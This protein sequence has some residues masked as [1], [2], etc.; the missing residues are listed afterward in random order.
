VRDAVM[1]ERMP[2][3]SQRKVHQADGP[4]AREAAQHGVWA[5]PQLHSCC[6]VCGHII[7]VS[8]SFCSS[9]LPAHED[10]AC[11]T[12]QAADPCSHAPLSGDKR[13]VAP[14]GSP[15]MTHVPPRAMGRS[16]S[17][18]STRWSTVVHAEGGIFQRGS[19]WD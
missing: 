7:F 8:P 9:F 18:C 5:A 3:A 10:T 12:G 2:E 17:P 16:G 4:C 11:C 1:A 15:H 13:H 6:T 19:A 14:S